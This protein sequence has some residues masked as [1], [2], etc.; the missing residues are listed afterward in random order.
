MIRVRQVV[1]SCGSI[2]GESAG[3]NKQRLDEIKD[4]VRNLVY[5]MYDYEGGLWVKRGM[6]EESNSFERDMD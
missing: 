5:H 1:D 3:I 6:L 2:S 4:E